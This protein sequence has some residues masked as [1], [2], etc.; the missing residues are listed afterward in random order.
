[1]FCHCVC[2]FPLLYRQTETKQLDKTTTNNDII[3]N[4]KI[5]VVSDYFITKSNHFQTNQLICQ[6]FYHWLNM[7]IISVNKDCK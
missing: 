4:I 1:M 3:Q 5:K 6:I 7:S 2:L